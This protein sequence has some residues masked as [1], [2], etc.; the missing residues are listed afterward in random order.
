MRCPRCPRCL[1]FPADQ[2]LSGHPGIPASRRTR[3][4]GRHEHDPTRA[5]SGK[6]VRRQF[7]GEDLVAYRTR[8]G[9]V[10]VVDPYCPHLGAHLGFG[11]LVDGENI[12]CPFHHFAYEF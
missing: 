5:T 10:R 2:G 9:I 11:G 7:M 3:P 4:L 8:E 12:V 1:R 6:V